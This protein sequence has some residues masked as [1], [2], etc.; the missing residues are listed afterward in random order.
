M[1]KRRLYHIWYG[2]LERCSDKSK[3]QGRKNWYLRGIRVCEKWKTFKVFEEWALKNG[4]DSSLQIDR[5]DNNKGYFPENCRW[6]THQTNSQNRSTSK[7]TEDD[8]FV[9]KARLLDGWTQK[10]LK[11]EFGISSGAMSRIANGKRWSNIQVFK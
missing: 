1:N 6:V 4:Y 5:K 8:I 2:M 3:G 9:I 10:C 7:L 11:S